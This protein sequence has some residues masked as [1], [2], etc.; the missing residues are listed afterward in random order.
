MPN[1][2]SI[3]SDFI[4]K[5]LG[6]AMKAHKPVTLMNI[7][8]GVPI[9]HLATFQSINQ[10]IVT[11]QVHEYQAVSIALE[12]RAYLKCD[13]LPVIVR[14]YPI[15][16]RLN[17]KHVALT[18][19]TSAERAFITR[20][21][22]RV[23]PQEPVKVDIHTGEETLS[24]TIADICTKGLGIFAFGAYVSERLNLERN[25]P[26]ELEFSL[27]GSNVAITLTG[28][29]TS[30]TREH[31][32]LLNRLGIQTT[33]VAVSEQE[34]IDYIQRRQKEILLELE[35]LYQGMLKAKKA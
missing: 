29:I 13:T 34:L 7:F 28:R 6:A 23:Q 12:K 27:P 26:V 30:I 3:S 5:Q 21:Y 19:F 24:G 8:R 4:L 11:L 10:G 35:S 1:P 18:R 32:T 15:L 16:V 33:P 9:E 2:P 17:E 14:A 25:H 22:L 31:G 20:S